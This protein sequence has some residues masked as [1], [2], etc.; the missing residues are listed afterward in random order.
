MTAEPAYSTQ[1]T[2]WD[3]TCPTWWDVEV[4]GH[5]DEDC[6]ENPCAKEAR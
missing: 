4:D 6:P 5:Y 1:S 3:C 2:R